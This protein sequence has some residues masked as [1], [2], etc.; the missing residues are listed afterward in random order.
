MEHGGHL[1]F[2]KTVNTII[3]FALLY[4]LLRKPVSKFIND[5]I[6][7][8]VSRFEK[9]KQEKEEA[10]RLLKE[11]EEKLENA[12]AEA[13]KVLEY[14][15]EVAQ[16]ERE[17]IVQEAKQTAKRIIEMAN[18]EIEKEVYRAKEELKKIAA[19]KAVEA[20]EKKLKA[21]VT[22]EVNKKLIESSLQK[23]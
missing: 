21:S 7:A 22:P 8:I 20:A 1:L 4:W 15:K 17:Q 3:L 6:N 10:L 14:S 9:A 11:A 5:G 19:Q 18:E 16:R 13:E 2:W 12:K 23:L